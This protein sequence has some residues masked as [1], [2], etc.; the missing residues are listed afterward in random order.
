M[1]PN[2]HLLVSFRNDSPGKLTLIQIETV[3]HTYTLYSTIYRGTTIITIKEWYKI[4][5]SQKGTSS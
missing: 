5:K 3:K 1:I 4:P 2:C